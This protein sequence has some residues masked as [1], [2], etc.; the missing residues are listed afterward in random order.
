M[1]TFPFILPSTSPLF[2]VISSLSMGKSINSDIIIPLEMLLLSPPGV[3]KEGED[4]D[5]VWICESISLDSISWITAD[6][7]LLW[8]LLL[9]LV[10]VL[11]GVE[12]TIIMAK[13]VD[14]VELEELE[15][16]EV[17]AVREPI[18]GLYWD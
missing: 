13:G 15:G 10:L 9:L 7:G 1:I 16:V 8:L 12:S 17:E 4:R 14:A 2:I 3:S 11:F 6:V 5:L 18:T